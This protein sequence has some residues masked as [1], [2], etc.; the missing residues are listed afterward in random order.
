[1]KLSFLNTMGNNKVKKTIEYTGY[2]VVRTIGG[3]K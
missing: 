1:M 3:S 2:P